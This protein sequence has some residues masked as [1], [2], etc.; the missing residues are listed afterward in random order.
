MASDNSLIVLDLP[1]FRQKR[2]RGIVTGG[3]WIRF[4]GGV[5]PEA[6]WSDFPVAAL[7]DRLRTEGY[8]FDAVTEQQVIDAVAQ[9]LRPTYRHTGL[10]DLMRTPHWDFMPLAPY[11]AW[12]SGLPAEV[13]P[14][15]DEL[16]G[17]LARLSAAWA[18]LQH[19]TADA[20]HELRSPLAALRLQ[21]QSLQR[22]ATPEARQIASERLIAGVECVGPEVY[23][24]VVR[25]RDGG[26]VACHVLAERLAVM[27]LDVHDGK[28]RLS[29]PGRRRRCW[30]CRR[31]DGPAPCR[32]IA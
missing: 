17:L 15:V 2:P 30:R 16:N 4:E 12:L 13:R 23:S 6:G 31:R 18:A 7:V 8:A 9:M 11:K 19:F 5:F 24:R 32:R 3:I 1:T 25:L 14:L 29:R 26:G 28:G 20:A 21:V 10:A 22:A 27:D